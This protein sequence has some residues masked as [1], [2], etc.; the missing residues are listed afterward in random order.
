M[1]R[2]SKRS[3]GR[4]PAGASPMIQTAIWMPAD[5]LAWLKAQPGT[6]S[7]NIRRLVAVEMDKKK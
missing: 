7:E 5:M 2:E 3:Q 4:P 6:M 1:K